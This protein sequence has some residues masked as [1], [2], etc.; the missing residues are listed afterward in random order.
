MKKFWLYITIITLTYVSC[1]NKKAGADLTNT[2][3]VTEQE[4]ILDQATRLLKEYQTDSAELLLLEIVNEETQRQV[5]Q[6]YIKAE[7]NLG[8]INSD[9]GNNV[10]ALQ[11]YQK[12][13]KTA[14]TTGDQAIMPHILKNIG[15]LYVQWKKFD[16]AFR[17]YD[18]AEKLARETGNEELL[19][20]CQNNKGTVYEQ[21][22]KYDLALAAYQSALSHY[23]TA[24]I[25]GKIAMAYS[26]MAIVYKLQKNYEE[27]VSYNLKAIGILEKLQDKWSMAATYNNIGNLYGE[28]GNY[29]QAIDYCKKSLSIAKEIEAE[30]IV[31]M[32]YESMANAAASAGDYKNAFE[33]H[34]SYSESMNKFINKESTQQ[35]SELNIKYETEKKE[36][37]IAETE[38]ASKQKNIWLI[39]LAGSILA[40]LVIFRNY[41]IKSKHKQQQFALEN[42]LLKEQ[43][44]SKMQE[45]RLEISR[46]LHDSLGAQLTFINSLLD[47]LKSA[48]SKLDETVNSKINTLSDFSEN[49]ITELKNALWVLNSKEIYLED[50]KSKILNFIKNASEAKEDIEFNLNFDVSENFNLNSR[51]AVSLFR[52]VQEIVNNALKYADATEIKIDVAQKDKN[53]IL[54][55]ADNGKG[56]DYEKEK[57]KSYGLQNIESRISAVNGTIELETASGKGTEYKIEIQLF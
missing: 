21:Q 16:E 51:Q 24:N 12:A 23:I 18:K 15:I 22:G 4:R 2:I 50:L 6:I 9:R 14:E 46:D 44:H 25:Q 5:P 1:T 45:Q 17:Y 26:N 29:N 56:F 42:E 48:S 32:A 30:E 28:I 54:K 41:R 47:G 52:A 31:G 27:S 43:T 38:L 3:P 39:L 55:I 10:L 8:K 34:K 19:A 20:D 53:L 11:H 57:N 49:S 36:K 40:G 35:L 37:L 33:F 7:L 13:I